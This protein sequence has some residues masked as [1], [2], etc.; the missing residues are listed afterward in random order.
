[1]VEHESFIVLNEFPQGTNTLSDLE[2][3]REDV[4]LCFPK[5]QTVEFKDGE[6]IAGAGRSHYR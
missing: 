4:L 1:M 6:D 3:D 5:D 2:L